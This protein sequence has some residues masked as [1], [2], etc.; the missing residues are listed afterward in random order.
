MKLL[1]ASLFAFTALVIMFQLNAAQAGAETVGDGGVDEHNLVGD[2]SRQ[3]PNQLSNFQI[4]ASEVRVTSNE[5]IL[6]RPVL[7]YQSSSKGLVV[8][9]SFYIDGEERYATLDLIC[10]RFQGS[11]AKRFIEGQVNLAEFSEVFAATLSN[12]KTLTYTWASTKLQAPI[13]SIVCNK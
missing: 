9:D 4:E 7:V 5:L 12:E 11:K 3:P 13:Q 1:N 8:Q 2:Y 10:Q 6:I